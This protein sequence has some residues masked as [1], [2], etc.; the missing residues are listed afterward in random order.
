MPDAALAFLSQPALTRLWTAVRRRL[1]GN[2]LEATGTLGLRDLTPEERQALSLLLARPVTRPGATIRLSE[3]DQ[4]LR[5]TA[6]GRGLVG[7]LGELGPPLTDR[8]AARTA[9][10]TQRNELWSAAEA[11]L[12]ATCLADEA[13]AEQWLDEARRG[14]AVARQPSDAAAA[15]LHQA[16]QILSLLFAHGAAFTWGRGELAIRFTGSAHGL[17][18]DTLLSRLVLRGIA[19]AHGIA[20]PGDAAGRRALWRAAS[21]TPDE[22]SS[23]VLTYGLRPTGTSWR[24][25]ALRERADHF[26]ETHLTLRELRALGLDLPPRTRIH[27]CE[28]PRIVEAAA[29]ARCTRPLVCTSGSAAT[30]V[31]TLLDML[32]RSGSRC[33][34]T[35]HGD[36]DWPGITLANRIM[37][38]YDAH[39]WRMCADDYDRLA[40]HTQLLG[41]P[42]LA[43][44]GPRVEADWD[45]GLAPAMEALGVALHEESAVDLLLEDLG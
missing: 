3:L 14:G 35:Y 22:V 6:A 19:R 29:D 28:N 13:W 44:A 27:V 8:R 26:T 4:R 34:L 41:M 18:D 2:G 20:F 25:A 10:R 43:L 42:Q 1:E 33:T 9:V 11:A 23:T 37:A 32:M 17:D 36:F 15:T 40:A 16:I 38:R 5:A 31:V 7:V 12:S 21:V 45:P 30:V 39:P 24:E